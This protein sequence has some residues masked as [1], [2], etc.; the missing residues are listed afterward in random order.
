MVHRN[1]QS[2]VND[3]R[4]TSAYAPF[5]AAAIIRVW[6]KSARGYTIRLLY[7]HKEYENRYRVLSLAEPKGPFLRRFCEKVAQI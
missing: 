1:G 4:M 6:S 2:H 3:G 5:S 7:R